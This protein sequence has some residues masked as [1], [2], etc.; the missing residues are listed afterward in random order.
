MD[1]LNTKINN[2]L[3]EKTLKIR[4]E[5]IKSG[6]SILGISGNV[7]EL[8]GETKTITPTT[9]QQTITPSQGK[10]GITQATIGAVTSS[11][12]ANITAGNI[13]K[14]VTI[15]NVT[16]TYEGIDTSDA[17]AVANDIVTGKTAYVNGQK[18]TGTYEGIIPT[19]T[20]SITQN[21]TVDVSNYASANVSVPTPTPNLQSKSVTI[22]EN[23]TTT[24]TADSGYDGLDEVEVTTNVSGGASEYNTKIVHY[25]YGDQALKQ[26][27][28]EI[29]GFNCVDKSMQSFFSGCYN[30]SKIKNC[31]WTNCRSLASTFSG[32]S[33]LSEL[34][35]DNITIYYNCALNSVF[36][37][38]SR[39]TNIDV[40][41]WT[42][43]SGSDI[44]GMFYGCTALETVD[45]SGLGSLQL[46]TSI[47]SWFRSCTNL[48][49]IN[50]P[51]GIN[52]R[53]VTNSANSLNYAFSGCTNLDN[54]TL[55]TILGFLPTMTKITTAS[56]K[57]LSRL[58]FSSDQATLM[59]TLS[60][61]SA[62]ETAGWTTGY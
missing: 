24:I 17:N 59:Q 21:G 27:M 60:N 44:S 30:L 25:G 41:H 49:T 31:T 37:G 47:G 8:N 3:T 53:S 43:W 11:I 16:G 14:D 51:S 36:S 42:G 26:A 22:T 15:L 13:K 32:C 4:P 19:G 45:I 61:W 9:S 20:K 50:F 12:D 57:T 6:I 46:V 54:N 23:G 5:N 29:N 38:C 55:N 10:N 39:L 40:H 58:G 48:R 52:L 62:C 2:I 33:Y 35:L 1:I 7:V 34:D 56:Y 28:S 18:L